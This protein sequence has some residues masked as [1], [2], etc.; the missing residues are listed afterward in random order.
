MDVGCSFFG[1]VTKFA[2]VTLGLYLGKK[3][4][5]QLFRWR[6]VLYRKGHRTKMDGS[7]F[8]VMV[9]IAYFIVGAIVDTHTIAMSLQEQWGV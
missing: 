1:M 8:S 9:I 5:W 7:I 2:E 4:R 3:G 6:H